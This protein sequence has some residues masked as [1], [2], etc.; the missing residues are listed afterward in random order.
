VLKLPRRT[1]LHLAAGAA[2][3][4]AI[5]SVARAQAYPSRPV[6]LIVGF[7]AGGS[8][9]LVTRLIGQRLSERLRRQIVIENRSGAGTNIATEAV[10]KASPDGYTLL[11]VTASNAINAALYNNL[12]FNFI[13]DIAPVSGIVNIPY[14]MVV[15][16]SVPVKTVS[17]FIAYAKANPGK[18]TFASSGS[19]ASS[20]VAGELFKIMAGVDMLHIPYR[21]SA[22]PD[23]LSGRV[24]IYF[25]PIPSSIEYI[26]TGK[27]RVLAV[28]SAKRQ[29]ALPDIPTVSEFMPGYEASNWTGIGAPKGT[30]AE[31]IDKLNIEINASLADPEVK[32]RLD[33]LGGTV[34]EGAPA[35]FAKL[36]ADE[37]E[38]W[39]KVIRAAKIMAE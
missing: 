39:G 15:N 36:I 1:F 3:L 23:L 12:N 25:S 22:L 37:T 2:A 31:I 14:V 33:E 34:I 21:S 8:V 17:E 13:R 32:A 19:G 7:A 18:L 4:P 29:E 26:R 10:V 27:L 9:D 16:P 20:H 6:H 35:D 11:S 28:T 5:S 24:E 38:K 30:S